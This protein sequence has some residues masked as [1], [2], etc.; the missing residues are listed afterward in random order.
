MFTLKK[1]GRNVKGGPQLWVSTLLHTKGNVST[2]R[3][4]DEYQR[5]K[6]P[7]LDRFGEEANII[8]SKSFLRHRV[9]H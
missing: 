8:P 7:K 9:L 5:D 2:E 4:W 1:I 6:S 3:I